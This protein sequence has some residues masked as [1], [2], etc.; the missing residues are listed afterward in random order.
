[1]A[2]AYSGYCSMKQLIVL[3]P[4]P[5]TPGWNASPSQGNPQQYV[6]GT[7]LYTW[8]ERDNVG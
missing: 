4:P 8:V 7:C 1:M 2:R 5:P 6:T 3:L